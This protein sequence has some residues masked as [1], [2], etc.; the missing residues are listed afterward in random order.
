MASNRLPNYLR[1]HR[2]RLGL[3]QTEVALLLGAESGAKTCR[4]ENFNRIPTLET[5]LACEV[6]FKK[7]VSEL[8]AGLYQQ[9]G[10]KVRLRAARELKR[11]KATGQEMTKAMRSL[12]ELAEATDKQSPT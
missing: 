12:M 10:R 3:S 1:G 5:A 8:F 7:P 4:Y 2:N 6:I 9:V 11:R